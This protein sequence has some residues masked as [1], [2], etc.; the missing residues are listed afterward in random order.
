MG[1]LPCSDNMPHSGN[2][3]LVVR[4]PDPLSSPRKVRT[5]FPIRPASGASAIEP[6]RDRRR[7][8]RRRHRRPAA[9]TVP[10][11]PRPLPSR[12]RRSFRR[13]HRRTPRSA[14]RAADRR[15]NRAKAFPSNAA[16][17][18]PVS[19]YPGKR[20]GIRSAAVAA[21]ESTDPRMS[22]PDGRWIFGSAAITATR[23]RLHLQNQNMP[24]RI[25]INSPCYRI[26]PRAGPPRRENPTPSSPGQLPHSSR[27]GKAGRVV[28]NRT[29]RIPSLPGTPPSGTARNPVHRRRTTS[30][31]PFLVAPNGSR[32]VSQSANRPPGR[33][34]NP[35]AGR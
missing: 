32:I 10:S 4:S 31:L 5:W 20:P 27:H 11:A 14:P 23:R 18:R 13:R 2:C 24:E 3:D 19:G 12:R 7:G 8:N 25:S 33:S 35:G 21:V 29:E 22:L 1:A 28:S 34:R 9:T 15:R 30:P 6:S 16:K 26:F 17:R